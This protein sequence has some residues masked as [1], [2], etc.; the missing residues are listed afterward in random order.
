MTTAEKR[1]GDRAER[2]AAS[3]LSD[4][5][6]IEVRRLLG[7]GRAD[8]IGDLAL[9]AVAIQVADW[10]N[11]P[12]AMRTK[13]LDA[14]TQAERSGLLCGAAMVRLRTGRWLV[15]MEAREFAT[16]YREATA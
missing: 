6:G 10:S 1:K 13:P 11:W 14:A 16:L 9:P 8:D 2:E 12:A 3:V 15:V 5:L 4:L 7:A